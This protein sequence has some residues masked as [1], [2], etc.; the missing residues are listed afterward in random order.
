MMKKQMTLSLL[1]LAMLA[2]ACGQEST[3][4]KDT[5]AAQNSDTSTPTETEISDDLPDTLNFEGKELRI[6]TS[7]D[8]K[9]SPVLVEE[10][11]GEVVNDA[12]WVRNEKVSERFGITMSESV[13]IW[14]EARDTARNTITSGDDAYDLISLIDREAVNCVIEGMFYPVE[15][16]QYIDLSKPYWIQSMNE[17][18]TLGG[19]QLLAYSSMMMTVYDFTY[20]MLF[21]KQLIEDMQLESPYDLVENGTW[22]LDNFNKYAQA[23]VSDL[24]GDLAYD[25]EDQYGITSVPRQFSPCVWIASDCLT[26]EKDS[27]DLPIYSMNNERMLDV[28]TF[29][30]ELTGAGNIWFKQ[31]HTDYTSHRTLFTSGQSLFT[32]DS[33][34]NLFKE[35]Y[36]A[37]TANYGLIPFPKFDEEQD[38]YYSRVEGGS[39]YMVPVTLED[40]SFSGAM[41]EALS[42]E[43]YNSVLPD[44]YDVALKVKLTRDE[45]SMRILDEIMENR[46]YDWGDTIFSN[47]IRDG[48]VVRAIVAGNPVAASDIEANRSKVEAAIDKVVTAFTK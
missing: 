32:C 10:Q 16:V 45:Q 38:S 8:T 43:S 40:T 17:N 26:I 9:H 41:L 31:Q 46:V 23:G 20:V 29:A 22:T 1:I 30:H 44:Y 42:C 19:R 35:E 6:L 18:L 12:L 14:S 7:K 47:Y 3:S 4:G 27:D 5:T 36:R 48:F 15:D 11:I 21:N 37:M 2:S 34:G 13:L 24:N 39:P 25:M 33:F 28:L